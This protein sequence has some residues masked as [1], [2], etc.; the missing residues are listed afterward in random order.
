MPV[1]SLACHLPHN[2]PHIPSR[3]NNEQTTKQTKAINN[4]HIYKNISCKC[5]TNRAGHFTLDAYASRPVAWLIYLLSPSLIPL[6]SVHSRGTRYPPYVSFVTTPQGGN[7]PKTPVAWWVKSQGRLWP[8]LLKLK[9]GNGWWTSN[10]GCSS[11]KK[12]NS[13]FQFQ[14]QFQGFQ[15]HQFQFQFQFQFRNWN[16]NWAAIPIPELNWPQPW[17]QVNMIAADALAP[18][19]CRVIN[20]HLTG[21]HCWLNY[22]SHNI[23]PMNRVMGQHDGCRYYRW[24]WS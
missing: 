9:F 2:T 11:C 12:F 10:C 7:V 18:N 6:A 4:S 23:Q 5:D 20:N 1:L 8:P 16:W 19:K 24:L 17:A 15:F 21:L 3:Y 22:P 14:F 13:G